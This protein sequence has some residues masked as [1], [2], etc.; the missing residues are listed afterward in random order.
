MNQ[1][2]LRQ[3]RTLVEGKVIIG[4]DPAKKK[5]QAALVD[6]SGIQLGSSFSFPVSHEG[7]EMILWK[8]IAKH[9]STCNPQEV[10]FA[11]ETSCNLWQTLAFYLHCTRGYTV[12]LVSPL[13]THHERPIMNLD[14]SRTDPKDAFLI[15]SLARRGAFSL[16]EQFSAHS[17][18][19]HALGITYDKLRKDLAR[20][21]SRLRAHLERIFPE[22]L[23]VLGPHTDSAIYLLKQYLFPD[24][25]LAL[26]IDAETSALERISR[27]QLG[28]A[29]LVRL[30]KLAHNSIGII[31]QNEERLADRLTLNAWIAQ[32]ETLEAQIKPVH[33]ELVH[34]AEQLP[35]YEIITSLSGVGDTLGSL[36]L[37]EVRDLA[38]YKHFKQL[39]KLAGANLRLSQ[40]GQYVGSRHISHIGN[41]RLLW[42]LYKMSEETARRVPEVRCKY[43][44]RQLKRRKHRKNVVAA[45]PQVLQLILALH[46][47]KRT[48]ETRATTVNEMQ[49]LE[50]RYAALKAQTASTSVKRVRLPNADHVAARARTKASRPHAHALQVYDLVE[51]KTP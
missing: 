31:K 39:E 36:F 28:R 47:E 16:Y 29:T 38:R 20:N 50:T 35:D 43:L 4:I 34:L 8:N 25:F 24:E 42:I 9:F 19:L 3:R 15:A 30:Q 23:S 12:V 10:I 33:T 1:E 5:H 37:A 27:R 26:D 6:E 21:R 49:E 32:I 44:R 40:S 17:N 45:I 13:S 2:K 11:V 46:K 22:F 51:E 14:F 7:F 18:A 48:Y 41:R